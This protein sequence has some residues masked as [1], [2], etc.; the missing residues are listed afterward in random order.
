MRRYSLYI[1]TVLH[2]YAIDEKSPPVP[3]STVDLRIYTES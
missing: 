1:G 3:Y 2:I